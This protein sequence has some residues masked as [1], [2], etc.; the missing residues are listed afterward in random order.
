[1]DLKNKNIL[2]ILVESVIVEPKLKLKMT[3]LMICLQKVV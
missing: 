1:M 2:T 3:L